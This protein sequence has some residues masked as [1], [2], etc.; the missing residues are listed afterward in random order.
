MKMKGIDMKKILVALSLG[1]MLTGCFGEPTFNS[2]NEKTISESALEMTKSMTEPEKKEFAQAVIY[3]TVGG[4]DGF[5]NAMRAIGS[6]SG[7]TTALINI[8][9]IDGLTA[10]EIIDKHKAYT[11]KD[12]VNAERR[13]AERRKNEVELERLAAEQRRNK[14]KLDAE[15]DEV[16]KIQEEA[17]ALLKSNQFEKAIAKYESLSNYSIGVESSKSGITEAKNAMKLFEEKMNYLKNVQITEFVAERK[18]QDDKKSEIQ[19]QISLKNAGE[20]SL[21]DVKVMVYFKDESGNIIS[22]EDFFPIER[23]KP[24][25]PGYVKGM[26]GYYYLLHYDIPGWITG[27]ATAKVVDVTFTE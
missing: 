3:F 4:A 23:D 20:R 10:S 17:M 21:D 12:R 16:L 13:A 18:D 5:R 24:L 7:V 25:K 15:L 19:V 2:T 27:N 1:L 8:H 14:A 22:E 26:S 11:E 9:S 6:P